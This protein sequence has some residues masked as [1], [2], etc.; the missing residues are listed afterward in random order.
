M[1][2]VHEHAAPTLIDYPRRRAI[3]QN[4][5]AANICQKVRAEF[6]ARATP[7]VFL[8]L[9][10]SLLPLLRSFELWFCSGIKG[11]LNL[12][13]Y[14]KSNGRRERIANLTIG[15]CFLSAELPMIRKALNAR[16][17][18][19][20]EPRHT[21][22]IFFGCCI[23][24]SHTINANRGPCFFARVGP[25]SGPPCFLLPPTSVGA[26]SH[27]RSRHCLASRQP[28]AAIRSK[29]ASPTVGGGEASADGQMKYS[30]VVF[31]NATKTTRG[32]VAALQNHWHSIAAIR[33]C[34][35]VSS[36]R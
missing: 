18:L 16:S 9:A 20:C 36:G 28:F 6:S 5:Y 23:S 19:N 7:W 22:E 30:A 33:R 4:P 21:N 27:A 11:C 8:P 3:H 35:L 24:D 10:L 34:T 26:I 12:N 25:R 2:A 29:R 15:G 1:C 13:S 14:R 31:F 17:H 32:A